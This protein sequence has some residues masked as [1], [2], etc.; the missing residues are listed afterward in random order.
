[1]KEK[2]LISI[3]M[4]CYNCATT[5]KEAFDSIYRQNFRYSFEIILVDDGSKDNT[6]EIIKELISGKKECLF[7]QHDRNRGGGAARNTAVKVSGGEFIFCL[8]SDDILADN[9]LPLMVDYIKKEKLDGAIFQ[10]RRFFSNDPKKYRED[11]NPDINRAIVLGDL[12][13]ETG[14]RVLFN[15]FVYTRTAYD[16]VGGYPEDHGFDTPEF[17]FTFLGKQLRA[18][19]CPNSIYY[20]RQA[21]KKKSYFDREYEKGLFSVYTY[22]GLEPSLDR[23][24]DPIVDLLVKFDVATKNELRNDN[25]LLSAI[26]EQYIKDG[27]LYFVKNGNQR[28]LRTKTFIDAVS[29][30]RSEKYKEALERLEICTKQYGSS[31]PIIL[32]NTIR[33]R[34]GSEGL[35][36]I[37]VVGAA[38]QELQDCGILKARRMQRVPPFVSKLYSICKKLFSIK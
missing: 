17:E 8:D 19:I 38:L 20:H 11:L 13:E 9:S 34:H 30:I 14:K 12:F 15:N 24:S 32:F 27:N 21:V 25:N 3:V 6:V 22:L 7:I 26:R 23:L 36:K 16:T 31:T 10:Y 35:E 37:K 33:A 18:K 2:P 1:M 5:L 29:L 28:S 4:P